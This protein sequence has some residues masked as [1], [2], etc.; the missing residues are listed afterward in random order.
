MPEV[1]LDLCERHAFL[2]ESR[3]PR[4]SQQMR[5]HPRGD[6]GFCRGLLDHLVDT[7][8]RVLEVTVG[9]EESPRGAIADDTAASVSGWP[10]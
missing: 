6:L 8:G 1:F 5:M 10:Q 7:P 9:F 4:V 3:A 2:E